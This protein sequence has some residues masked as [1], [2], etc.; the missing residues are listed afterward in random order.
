MIESDLRNF[1]KHTVGGIPVRTVFSW[2]R[3]T[4]TCDDIV[5]LTQSYYFEALI[6]NRHYYLDFILSTCDFMNWNNILCC[7]LTQFKMYVK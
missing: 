1:L 2:T 4:M 6:S 7:K 5:L 3:K